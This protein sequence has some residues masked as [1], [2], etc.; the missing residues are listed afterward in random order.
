MA[1]D[2]ILK[3][4]FLQEAN[5]GRKAVVPLVEGVHWEGF[6][7][8]VRARL[9]LPVG[10]TVHLRD[11]NGLPIDSMDRLLEADESATLQIS[12]IVAAA[13]E[14]PASSASA[15]A[16]SRRPVAAAQAAEH[17]P[18]PLPDGAE[19]FRV[20]IKTG[21]GVLGPYAED[22]ELKYRKRRLTAGRMSRRKMLGAAIVL[23]V[24]VGFI[25][26]VRAVASG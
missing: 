26:A 2:G 20:D 17:T 11:D 24:C 19:E 13:A 14:M 6:L 4:V 8:R 23:F 9:G 18:G 3:L 15:A 5:T 21:P 12:F 10:H 25:G 16:A 7:T 1:D 22:G